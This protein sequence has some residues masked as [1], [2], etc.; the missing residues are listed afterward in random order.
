MTNINNKTSKYRDNK[1]CKLKKM[2]SKT[3]RKIKDREKPT[4]PKENLMVI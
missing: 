2:K 4:L 3:F 1:F